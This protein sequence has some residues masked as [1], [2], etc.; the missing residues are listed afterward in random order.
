MSFPCFKEDSSSH[1]DGF[2]LVEILVVILIIGILAAVAIPV[3]LNQRQAANDA[4]VESDV[5]NM[6]IA[7]ENFFVANPD[8]QNMTSAEFKALGAR[9][10]DVYLVLGGSRD[11]FCIMGSHPNGKIYRNWNNGAPAGVRPYVLYQS[12]SGG[13]G[14]KNVSFSS[15]NCYVP[16]VS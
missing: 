4:A 11:D 8:R 13:T 10:K 16:T 9:S 7:V 1:E 12:K 15:L 3:F 5:S 2:T 14:D 6:A